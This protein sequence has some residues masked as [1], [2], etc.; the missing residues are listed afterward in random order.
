MMSGNL[1]L[2]CAPGHLARHNGMALGT[3][4][5]RRPNQYVDMARRYRIDVDG[6]SVVKIKRGE[7]MML[8]V[9]VGE[10][11]AVAKIDWCRSNFLD[12]TIREDEPTEIEVSA[13]HVARKVFGMIYY[14]TFGRTEYLLLRISP[15]GF[16]VIAATP[17]DTGL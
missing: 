9:S 11:R 14:I 6:K 7:E 3:L 8:D 4:I 10:H 1:F 17:M 12:I 5:I 16:P 15:R 2:L 13:N